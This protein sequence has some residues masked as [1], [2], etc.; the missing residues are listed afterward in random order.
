MHARRIA[1]TA[2]QEFGTSPQHIRLQLQ[3]PLQCESIGYISPEKEFDFNVIIRSL[4]YNQQSKYL[5]CMVG[6][7]ITLDSDPESEYQEC[8]IKAKSVFKVLGQ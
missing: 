8:L 2:S 3:V 6:G 1:L 5:S 7:A 4:F